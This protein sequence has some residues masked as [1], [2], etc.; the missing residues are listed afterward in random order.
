M[1]NLYEKISKGNPFRLTKEQHFIPKASIERFTSNDKIIIKQ[2]K[3]KNKKTVQVNSN[4]DIFKVKRLWSQFAESG[5]MKEI[6]E[7]FQ[8][9]VDLI[10]SN[11][12]KLTKKENEIIWEMFLL[13]KHRTNIIEFNSINKINNCKISEI[14]G[15]VY[16]NLEKEKL[17]SLELS[18]IN[19]DAEIIARD[20]IANMI[21]LLIYSEYEIV[22]E[23]EWQI[24]KFSTDSLIFPS[25]PCDLAILPINPNTCLISMNNKKLKEKELNEN[26]F[27]KY[28]NYELKKKAKWFYFWKK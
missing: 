6:E 15:D 27:I 12:V 10:I 26:E 17:E 18:Y 21:L 4:D 5:Y 13:W 23:Y 16:S 20:Y 24:V 22:K 14:K 9:L 3:T 11:N 19:E 25:N 8:K 1:N 28:I 7:K 2:L